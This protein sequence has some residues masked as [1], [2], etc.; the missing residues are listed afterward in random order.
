[1]K[2]DE[3]IIQRPPCQK[4]KLENAGFVFYRHLLVCGN[5]AQKFAEKERIWLEA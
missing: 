5:C 1:M 4:C 2:M 3:Q